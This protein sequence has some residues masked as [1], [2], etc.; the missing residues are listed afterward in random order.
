M[1]VIFHPISIKFWL[2][3]LENFLNTY[4]HFWGK[5]YVYFKTIFFFF[6]CLLIFDGSTAKTRIIFL[7][8]SYGLLRICVKIR[9][10]PV[11]Y[12]LF[13]IIKWLKNVLM[14]LYWW[15]WPEIDNKGLGSHK[16]SSFLFWS[17]RFI[18][19]KYESKCYRGAKFWAYMRLYCP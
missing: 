18:H 17:E 7:I 15:L 10:L 8:I 4:M 13:K 9:I 3:N 2:Y 19:S 1:I 5:I 14:M 11:V 6:K 16:A 12:C